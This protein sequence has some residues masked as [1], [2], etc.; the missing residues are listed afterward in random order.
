MNDGKPSKEQIDYYFKTSRK[1]FDSLARQYQMTDVKF[2]QDYFEPYYNNPFKGATGKK[3]GRVVLLGVAIAVLGVGAS[4]FVF[5]SQDT[6]SNKSKQI[7]ESATHQSTTSSETTTKTSAEKKSV[8]ITEPD[9]KFDT[10]AVSYMKTDFEKGAY[11]YGRKNY[12]MAEEYLNRIK[13]SDREYYAA[14]DVLRR[15]EKE[16]NDRSAKKKALEKIN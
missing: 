9:G 12:E 2:Y 13:K 8:T 11:Y 14:K 5:L 3:A 15:I 4:V 10:L 1:Y 16:K 7:E 6:N